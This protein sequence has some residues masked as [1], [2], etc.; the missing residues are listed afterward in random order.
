VGN[1][2]DEKKYNYKCVCQHEKQ[3]SDIPCNKTQVGFNDLRAFYPKLAL[4][5]SSAWNINVGSKLALGVGQFNW[6]SFNCG[7]SCENKLWR[8]LRSPKTIQAWCLLDIMTQVILTQMQISAN[9]H[10]VPSTCSTF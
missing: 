8:I 7:T 2:V 1:A 4:K 10:A 3:A 5:K 9:A 6:F